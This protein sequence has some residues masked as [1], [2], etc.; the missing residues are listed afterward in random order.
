MAATLS[1]QQLLPLFVLT[2][3]GAG[4]VLFGY[5]LGSQL[6]AWIGWIG[7]AIVG[8]AVGWIGTPLAAPTVPGQTHLLIT[9]AGLVGGGLIG[10]L[11]LPTVTRLAV[12][13]SGFIATAGAILAILAG[14]QLT[15]IATL[16]GPEVLV[17]GR[18]DLLVTRLLT[19]PL[20]EDQAY[21]QMLVIALIGGL[22]GGLVASRFYQVVVTLAAT[23]IGAIIIGIVGPL[24]VVTY[25]TGTLPA[26]S[27]ETT[28]IATG[29]VLA[30]VL[31]GGG[32]QLYRH[33]AVL[34]GTLPE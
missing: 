30:A 3:V 7:G 23:G 9:V 25:Q 2:I 13:L 4:F 11:L 20:I 15:N 24:W 26:Y 19:T 21:Q 17:N 34:D 22:L 6:L 29:W 1:I 28:G 14:E 10:R 27:P 33:R 18:V 12:V 16:V 8:A 5:E 32:T 31:I